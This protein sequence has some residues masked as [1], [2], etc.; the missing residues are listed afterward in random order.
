MALVVG[1]HGIAQQNKGPETLVSEW[2]PAL[3]DG[4]LAAGGAIPKGSL[5]CAFYGSLFRQKGSVRAA[6]EEHFQ[7]RDVTKDEAQLLEALLA[8]AARA[9][10]ERIPPAGATL[11]ASTPN[12]IQAGLRLLAQS[13]FFVGIAE[14]AMI[15][16]LKQV[17]RYIREP[18]IRD[19][20]QAAVDAVVTADT[21][22]IVGHS[23]GSVVAYEALHRYAD[24]PRWANVAHFITLGSPLGIPTLIFDELSPEPAHGKGFSPK[25]VSQWSNISD[26]GDIVAL[27]KK[28]GPLFDGPLTDYRIHNGATA[29]DVNPYLTTAETGAAIRGALG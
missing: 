20:A 9:E 10:P 18:D 5:S 28:L 22:V 8:E 1:V 3:R 23:L 15:G 29:H 13:R 7:A 16:D 11:R 26:D 12:A 19:A 14:K 25:R 17:R 6:G 24:T 4:V 27:I 21:R 2:E